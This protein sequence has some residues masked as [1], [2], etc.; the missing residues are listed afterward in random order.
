MQIASEQCIKG[1]LHPYGSWTD[2]GK[3]E[4]IAAFEKE[5]VLFLT[6]VR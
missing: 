5:M 2:L 6:N 4:S 3:L 1:Y